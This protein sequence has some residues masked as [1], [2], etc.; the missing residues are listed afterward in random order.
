[1][2]TSGRSASEMPCSTLKN[3]VK[4]SGIFDTADTANSG[5]KINHIPLDFMHAFSQ[6]YLVGLWLLMWKAEI[7]RSQL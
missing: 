6:S 2:H 7:Y 1:M 5:I 4:N 3:S